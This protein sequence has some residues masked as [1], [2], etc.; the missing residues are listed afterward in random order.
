[1]KVQ[2]GPKEKP[3]AWKAQRRRRTKGPKRTVVLK[4]SRRAFIFSEQDLQKTRKV[5]EQGTARA[6]KVASFSEK[7]EIFFFLKNKQRKEIDFT[8]TKTMKPTDF[9]Q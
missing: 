3:W 6:R 1:V 7:K 2:G 4:F 9:H 5:T 8:P